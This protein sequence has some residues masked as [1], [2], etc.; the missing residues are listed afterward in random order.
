MIPIAI[1][2]DIV[3]INVPLA[4]PETSEDD[5]NNGLSY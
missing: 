4:E 3:K 2:L 5:E 1:K